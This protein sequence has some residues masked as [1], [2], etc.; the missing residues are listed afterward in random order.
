MADWF[1]NRVLIINNGNSDKG[2]IAQIY[3]A[4]K[5]QIA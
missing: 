5:S 2:F 4:S 3:K 1:R